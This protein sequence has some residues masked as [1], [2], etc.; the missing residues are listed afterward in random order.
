MTSGDA[1]APTA[2]P[3]VDGGLEVQYENATVFF[4]ESLQSGH[5]VLGRLW[6][7]TASQPQSN[8]DII[9]PLGGTMDAVVT[10]SN[11]SDPRFACTFSVSGTYDDQTNV[12]ASPAVY[13]V[14]YNHGSCTGGSDSGGSF[15]LTQPPCIP[16]PDARYRRR[17][18]PYHVVAPC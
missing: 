2:S 11:T 3:P 8:G 10:P 6:S 15:T 12:S 9:N 5:E 14:I 4:G 18:R 13:H 7:L 17:V 1:P 16:S